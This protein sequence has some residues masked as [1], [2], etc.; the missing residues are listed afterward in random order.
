MLSLLC[1]LCTVDVGNSYFSIIAYWKDKV[2]V[3]SL[4]IMPL[5]VP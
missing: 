1:A 3:S 2:V 4:V 5:A